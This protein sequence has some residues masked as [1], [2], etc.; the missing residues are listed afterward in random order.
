MRALSGFRT[1]RVGDFDAF[2]SRR[3]SGVVGRLNP[4]RDTFT[5]GDSPTWKK[6]K[7]TVA[8]PAADRVSPRRRQ[9]RTGLIE[10]VNFQTYDVTMQG[11]NA[12]AE[13]LE[14][15]KSCCPFKRREAAPLIKNREEEEEGDEEE[16]EEEE[17]EEGSA[18]MAAFTQRLLLSPARERNTSR[19]ARQHKVQNVPRSGRGW[20]LL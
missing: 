3:L 1:I 11:T 7:V 6:T 20:A 10:L 19:S 5:A 13:L 8:E 12:P 18:R 15:Q 2:A 4:D 16:E 9:A 17:E 14:R